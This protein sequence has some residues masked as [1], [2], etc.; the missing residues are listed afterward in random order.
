M[1]INT[2]IQALKTS[3]ILNESNKM[4]SR[5]LARLSSGSKIVNPKDDALA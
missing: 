5:S 3:N 4:L 2:N 1:I